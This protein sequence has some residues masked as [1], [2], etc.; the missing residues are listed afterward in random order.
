MHQNIKKMSI[1]HNIELIINKRRMMPGPASVKYQER[2][3][4]LPSNHKRINNQIVY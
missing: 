2:V 4:R 3:L 1:K